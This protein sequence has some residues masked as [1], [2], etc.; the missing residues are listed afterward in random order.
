M[1]CP[2]CG[3]HIGRFELDQ[4]C[5]HCGVNLFYCQQEKLLSD[6]AKKCELEYA[7]FRIFTA[8]LKAAF[9][10]G[11]LPIAR[12]VMSIVCVGMLFIPFV[13]A[14][15]DLSLFS[16]KL[17]VSG[18]G[19][20]AAFSDGSLSALLNLMNIGE[21]KALCTVILAIIALLI[22]ILLCC[23]ALLGAEILSFT[24]IRRSA[25][26]MSIISAVGI[27]FSIAAAVAVIV[28]NGKVSGS[29]NMLFSVS[30]GFG[31]YACAVSL[32][33]MMIINI[34]IVKKNIHA[35][36]KDVDI[37][38]IKMRKR[39]K[40]GEVSLESLTLPVFESEEEKEKR[41]AEEEKSKKLEDEAKD[42]VKNGKK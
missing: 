1:N 27:L 3:E 13:S 15:A 19:L 14:N 2:N 30:C 6:D 35:D 38:R 32:A 18:Y 7:S 37:E 17:T 23:I 41:I 10:K 40:S 8:K 28:L 34:L 42:G 36:I 5:K 26:A 25:K 22:G 12:I 11:P 4:H 24:N 29:E 9:I 20:Y 21:Y 39:V 16:Q 31:Q 33:V